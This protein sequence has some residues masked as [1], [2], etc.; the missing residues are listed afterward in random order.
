M[1][2]QG[3]IVLMYYYIFLVFILNTFYISKTYELQIPNDFQVHL[4]VLYS[5]LR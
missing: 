4:F 2:I 3:V 1:Y 5:V